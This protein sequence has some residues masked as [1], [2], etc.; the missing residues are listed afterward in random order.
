MP[1]AAAPR[2][3]WSRPGTSRNCSRLCG[4]SEERAS[5]A[6]GGK[7]HCPL[8]H[9]MSHTGN[10]ARRV[11]R[12]DAAIVLSP[13]LMPFRQHASPVELTIGEDFRFE[14]IV[15]VHVRS[16]LTAQQRSSVLWGPLSASGVQALGVGAFL[17]RAP[18]ADGGPPSKASGPI[19]KSA[20]GAKRATSAPGAKGE[21]H[22]HPAAIG[23]VR[24]TEFH[25]EPTLFAACL[26]DYSDR[27]EQC[28]RQ[29]P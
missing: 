24:G 17:H 16:S 13:P 27:Y 11:V 19:Y 28:A 21:Q 29:P 20:P 9:R 1:S 25:G 2:L 7:V 22:R 23:A 8:R 18:R 10:A 14:F 4:T 3:T 6:P 5:G 26:H 15:L 12:H